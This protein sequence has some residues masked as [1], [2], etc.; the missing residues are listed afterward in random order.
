MPVLLVMEIPRDS[1][2]SMS[3]LET[4]NKPRASRLPAVLVQVLKAV[5][6]RVSRFL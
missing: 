6:F 5:S 4:P 2:G 3:L 1:L